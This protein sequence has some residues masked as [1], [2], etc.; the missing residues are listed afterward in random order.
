MTISDHIVETF[1]AVVEINCTDETNLLH[2]TSH[3]S[4]SIEFP[5]SVI[6]NSPSK[7]GKYVCI[8]QNNNMLKEIHYIQV[9]GIPYCTL[10]CYNVL[11]L[12]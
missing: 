10:N 3:S 2:D 12:A 1:N 6:V 9:K 5:L 7:Q 11:P 8:D 4:E